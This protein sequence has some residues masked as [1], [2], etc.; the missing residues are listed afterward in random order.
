DAHH[1][2]PGRGR[3]VTDLVLLCRRCHRRVHRFKWKVRIQADGAITFTARGRTH[4]SHPRHR[5]PPALE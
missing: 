2:V 5:S 1:L 3:Q 4:T